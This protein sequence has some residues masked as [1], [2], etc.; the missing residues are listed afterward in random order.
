MANYSKEFDKIA[1]T[2][3]A[4]FPEEKTK[5]LL[6]TFER[7]RDVVDMMVYEAYKDG[8]E[9]GIDQERSCSNYE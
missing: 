9:E 7:L 8:V 4:M 3:V 1:A 5:E 2:I 6:L